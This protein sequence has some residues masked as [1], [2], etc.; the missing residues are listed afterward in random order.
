VL[1]GGGVRRRLPELRE[2]S[3]DLQAE[4][5]RAG[6]LEEDGVRRVVMMSSNEIIE[7]PTQGATF[8]RIAPRMTSGYAITMFTWK[9]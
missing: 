9:T 5:W 2:P 4:G 3:A 7:L 1:N 6:G 8:V